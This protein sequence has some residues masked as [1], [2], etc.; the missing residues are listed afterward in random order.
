MTDTPMRDRLHEI[1]SL[2]STLG[3]SHPNEVQAFM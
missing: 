2:L 3:K 1:E